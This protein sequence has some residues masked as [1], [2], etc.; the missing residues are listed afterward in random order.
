MSPK[1]YVCDNKKWFSKYYSPESL[2]LGGDEYFTFVEFY[3]PCLLYT[4]IYSYHF[5]NDETRQIT[6]S[7]ENETLT[8]KAISPHGKFL[9][10]KSTDN[11]DY[12]YSYDANATVIGENV[13]DICRID[14]Y[15]NCYGV[16]DEDT[17]VCLKSDGT[18][19]FSL[20]ADNAYTT[21]KN[22]GE[23]GYTV[24]SGTLPVEKDF[25]KEILF[26]ESGFKVYITVVDLSLI[27]IY[28]L[29]N[30]RIDL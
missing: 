2:G 15:G 18:A 21:R 13:Y 14:N 24:S 22:D 26:D 9:M 5:G 4:S 30:N 8:L 17:S 29:G 23:G 16:S 25:Q 3:L 7:P 12:I 10:Y 20:N 1:V 11:C 19:A 28:C 27:H 6:G